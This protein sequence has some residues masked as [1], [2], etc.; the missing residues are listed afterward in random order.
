MFQLPSRAEMRARGGLD[1]EIAGEGVKVNLSEGSPVAFK[2]PSAKPIV[3]DWS[4][5]EPIRKYFFRTGYE[6]WPSWLYHPT[7]EPRLV[8]NADEAMDLGVLF[9]EPTEDERVRYGVSVGVWDQE[10]GCQ[11]RPQPYGKPKFD[12]HRPDTGKEVIWPRQDPA[13]ILAQAM[14]QNGAQISSAQTAVLQ[15]LVTLLKG[16]AGASEAFVEESTN[17][18]AS[19][20][21]ALPPRDVLEAEAA[22][23]GIKVDGRWSNAKLA[24]H[25]EKHRG[26]A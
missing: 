13:T 8:N 2:P 17:P 19:Q 21:A 10:A 5:F 3:P 15:E 20:S 14:R 24:E 23:L 1:L 9:R 7:E 22:S 18:L 26:N 16:G 11:W 25:I 12:P 4:T 6:V